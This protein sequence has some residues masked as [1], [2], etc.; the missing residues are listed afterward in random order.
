[1]EILAEDFAHNVSS[2]QMMIAVV[3]R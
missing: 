2:R 1:L 3:G